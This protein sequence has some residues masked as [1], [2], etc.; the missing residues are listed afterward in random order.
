VKSWISNASAWETSSHGNF[1]TNTTDPSSFVATTNEN[2]SVSFS[3]SKTYDSPATTVIVRKVDSYPSDASDGTIVYNSTGTV[4][5]DTDNLLAGSHWY[6]RAWGYVN[7]FS[8]NY[9]EDYVWVS[10]F[11]P[12]NITTNILSNSTFDIKWDNGTGARTTLIRR[13]LDAYPT[14]FTDGDEVYNSTGEQ[15]NIQDLEVSYYYSLWSYANETYSGSVNIT[16]GGIVL[17]CFDEDTNETL[18]FDIFISNEDGS[19]THEQRNITNG[20]ILNVTDLPIGDAVKFVVTA[21]QNYSDQSE[22][23]SF[24][25]D[26]NQTITYIVL[27]YPPEDK[28]STNV[29]CINETAGTNSYPPFTLVDDL[30]TILADDADNFTKVFVNYTYSEYQSRTYHRTITTSS[31]Y[32]LN[33]YLPPSNLA[34]LYLLEV[35]DQ[36]DLPLED[37]YIQVKNK[38]NNTYVVVSSLYT[39]ANGQADLY[40]IENDNY[41][42]VISKSGYTTENAS[43]TPGGLIFTHTFKLLLE[44]DVDMPP[45]F[46]EIINLQGVISED[47]TLTVTFY[48]KDDAMLNSHFFV[49]EYYNQTFSYMGEYNGTTSNSFSFTV[50]I[51]NHSRMHV[52]RLYMNHSNLGETINYTIYVMPIMEERDEGNWLESLIM[53]IFGDWD[54]G[55]IVT[56]I[57]VIPCIMLLAGFGAM[58]QPGIGILGVGM[59]SGWFTSYLVMPNEGDILVIAGIALI[60]AFIVIV[61]KQSKTVV[62]E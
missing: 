59:W 17:Y 21:S 49:E 54:Y 22:E 9:S 45:E 53:S 14:D 44:T 8:V 61:L 43:W 2:R 19:Q 16:V 42:F 55:Y 33:A 24:G 37:A 46:G 6:Y 28:F 26:E 52:I 7:P 47:N 31:F 5:T 40:L 56:I 36:Y 1:T 60:V 4:Y 32:L 57:W 48:D 3:W 23:F 10:P 12:D 25:H 51:V 35:V 39:D 29:T 18:E 30:V 50:D 58:H 38:V 27:E 34:N 62:H 11:P 41:I 15:H 13:K 20:Y